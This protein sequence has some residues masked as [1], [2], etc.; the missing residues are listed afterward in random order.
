MS[1]E[2]QSQYKT[3]NYRRT[4]ISATAG[5]V[6]AV[7]VALLFVVRSFYSCPGF[8][9]ESYQALCVVHWKQAPLGM[10]IFWQAHLWTVLF[11]DS[12]LSLRLFNSVIL[13]SA[14]ALSAWYFYYRTHLKTYAYWVFVL[15]GFLGLI[16]TSIMYCWDTGPMV[17]YTLV[18]IASIEYIIT[19]KTYLLCVLGCL[20]CLL[21]LSR[22]SLIILFP[23]CLCGL[24]FLK[25]LHTDKKNIARNALLFTICY[26][27]TFLIV[28]TLMSGSPVNYIDSFVPDN[29]ISGH[30]VCEVIYDSFYSIGEAGARQFVGVF[31]V[32]MGLWLVT[33]GITKQKLSVAMVSA[34]L[35]GLIELIVTYDGKGV[36]TGYSAAGMGLL[37]WVL[38]LPV[39][40]NISNNRKDSTVM[41]VVGVMILWLIIP[42]LGSDN[43]FIRCNASGLLGVTV[44]GLY[45]YMTI[46]QRSLIKNTFIIAIVAYGTAGIARMT[47]VAAD[48]SVTLREYPKMQGIHV[49]ETNKEELMEVFGIVKTLERAGVADRLNFDGKRYLFNYTLQKSPV[50]NLHQFHWSKT[51]KADIY[52]RE[53]ALAQYDGWMFYDVTMEKISGIDS[54]LIDNGFVC[55]E[56]RITNRIDSDKCDSRNAKRIMLFLKK[57]YADLYT[58]QI[59]GKDVIKV[60]NNR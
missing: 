52:K 59:D 7:L 30:S 12:Y 15:S 1:D 3:G 33:G 51:C 58:K 2:L 45:P 20:V 55:V 50:Y 42:S 46:Q 48:M 41:T 38:A 24:C 8:E 23:V 32:C 25:G 22:V 6:L 54:M 14:F 37:L 56:N 5:I 11:G 60:K 53:M 21:G 40:S 27:I 39:L 29:I 18:A 36:E 49:T 35:T 16:E 31:S 34:F 28:T 13:M 9:D 10:F 44:A 57:P 26:I 47:C 43:M 17:L 4:S 19:K